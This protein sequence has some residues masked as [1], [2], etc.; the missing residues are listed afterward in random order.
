MGLKT[1]VAS[2]ALVAVAGL[3]ALDATAPA[4]AETVCNP[5]ST[6]NAVVC[7]SGSGGGSG[8]APAPLTGGPTNGGGGWSS[9]DEPVIS[10]HGAGGSGSAPAPLTEAPAEGGGGVVIPAEVS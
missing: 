2:T 9:N 4:M 5:V 8:T 6:G 3:F 10:G 7:G 1:I